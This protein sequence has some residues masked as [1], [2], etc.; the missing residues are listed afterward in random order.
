[1]NL[2]GIWRLAH[3]AVPALLASAPP[4]RGR[5]V[6][7]ASAGATSGSRCNR[8][9]R[10]QGRGRWAWCGP[11]RRAGTQEHH[12]QHRRPGRPTRGCSRPATRSTAGVIGRVRRPPPPPGLVT[13]DQVAALVP[14]C[15]ARRAGPP[16]VP[17]SPSTPAWPPVTIRPTAGPLLQARTWLKRGAGAPRV[18]APAGLRAL[19]PGVQKIAAGG[20]CWADRR[21]RCCARQP[22][23]ARRW[24]TR[25]PRGRRP[26]HPAGRSSRP[27]PARWRP[28]PP[29]GRGRRRAGHG[30]R[31][32][33]RRPR[34]GPASRPRF[35]TARR[36]RAGRQVVVV[37]G[38]SP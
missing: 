32:G 12:R 9:H 23:P 6:A 5:F 18:P 24:S 22:G 10:G 21:C 35:P 16:P 27:P 1:M 19:D 37:V 30:R 17:C 20:C 15:P 8:L 33:H 3:A 7:V 29:T 28:G 14:G 36:P 38:G 26:D 34:P 25:R 2:E 4:S 13:A 31:R 11:R